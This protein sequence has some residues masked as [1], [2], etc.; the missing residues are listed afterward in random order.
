MA[1]HGFAMTPVSC[2]VSADYGSNGV[3]A[4]VPYDSC[5]MVR[6]LPK[7]RL[8]DITLARGVQ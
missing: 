6:V 3:S 8:A 2:A 7:P 4:A 5:V 1:I